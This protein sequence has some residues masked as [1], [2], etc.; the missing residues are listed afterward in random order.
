ML[1]VAIRAR[2]ET[3]LGPLTGELELLYFLVRQYV[4]QCRSF[5]VRSELQPQTI[6]RCVLQVYGQLSIVVRHGAPL[7]EG[8]GPAGASASDAARKLFGD[9]DD[10]PAPPSLDSL[11]KD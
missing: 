9:G 10:D 1:L 6:A 11:F 3:E 7:A 2:R 5:V 4:S 8:E